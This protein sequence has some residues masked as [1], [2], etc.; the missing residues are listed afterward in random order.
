MPT[1][2][3]NAVTFKETLLAFLAA[4]P[5]TTVVSRAHSNGPLS[6]ARTGITRAGSAIFGARRRLATCMA[7]AL[8]GMVGYHVVVGQNGL[9][10][11]RSKR[12]QMRDIKLQ[13]SEL[14]REN[15]RLH[16]HV[17]RLSSDPNA[18]EHEAREALHYTR[19]GEVI[20][21][22]PAENSSR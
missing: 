22:M 11:Y 14:Q 6:L 9:V 19:P 7:V 15:S 4:W 3:P 17:D 1:K 18:I 12:D 8:A 13:M 21:T 10:S 20:Y 5:F 16:N 2:E